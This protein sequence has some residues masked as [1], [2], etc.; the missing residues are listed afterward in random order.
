MNHT[1]FTQ[2][3]A[4][5]RIRSRAKSFTGTSLS[6]GLAAVLFVLTLL[7]FTNISAQAHPPDQVPRDLRWDN[8]DSLP[9]SLKVVWAEIVLHP[10]RR[11]AGSLEGIF[12][13]IPVI[14]AKFRN[15]LTNEWAVMTYRRDNPYHLVAAL[16]PDPSTDGGQMLSWHEPPQEQKTPP[17]LLPFV[18]WIE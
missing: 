18:K 17:H 5:R 1:S 2:Q 15:A 8:W 6:I 10:T 12:R 13:G 14:S 9:L 16:F 3:L 7:P 4:T 11:V